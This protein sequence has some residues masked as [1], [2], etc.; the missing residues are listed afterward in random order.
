MI[1][2]LVLARRQA[3]KAPAKFIEFALLGRGLLALGDC[4][5]DD[6]QQ[7]VG[8]RRLL[9]EIERTV[10]HCIDTERNGAMAGQIYHRKAA[11]ARAQLVVQF[12]T[13]HAR[14]ADVEQD[15]ADPIA[16][17]FFEEV[18][19]RG[20]C[21]D[22]PSGRAQQPSQAAAYVRV[23]VDH[24]NRPSTRIH[25]RSPIQ[26]PSRLRCVFFKERAMGRRGNAAAVSSIA[27]LATPVKA[28]CR[29][30]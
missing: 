9:D 22:D 10:A 15:A 3:R 11:S 8:V 25:S 19:G 13:A 7:R 27:A 30:A 6:A 2:D 4:V 28:Q 18:L 20:V 17:R 1:H 21:I 23:V 16:R 5:V 12:R 26:K 14:H 24:V 29:G